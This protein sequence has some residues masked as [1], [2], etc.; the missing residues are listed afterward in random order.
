MNDFFDFMASRRSSASRADFAQY[1]GWVAHG[2]D[3][4]SFSDPIETI[5]HDGSGFLITNAA[6]QRWHS[7]AVS[8]GIGLQP[9]IPDFVQPAA[10]CLHTAHW[11]NYNRPLGGRRAAII[12][13]GQ[14]GAE[15][16]LDLLKRPE[17]PAQIT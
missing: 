4:T 1:M 3:N 17:P 7:R 8:I 12:G 6:G 5:D 2:L 10:D 16:V 13:G 11:L 9:N 15:I 14:S